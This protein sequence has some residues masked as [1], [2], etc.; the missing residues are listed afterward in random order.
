MNSWKTTTLLFLITGF[1]IS[2]ITHGGSYHAFLQIFCATQ[3]PDA[4]VE[5]YK[6]PNTIEGKKAFLDGVN[7]SQ[8]DKSWYS[9]N[10][11]TCERYFE[12]LPMKE[13]LLSELQS[14][15]EEI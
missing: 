13:G 7:E 5:Y 8:R 9:W 14:T 15:R 10:V 3:F 6:G 4:S 2:S 11:K 1:L 12:T